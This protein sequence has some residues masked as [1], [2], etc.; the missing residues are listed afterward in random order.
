MSFADTI[1]IT[2]NGVAKVLTRVNS[3]QD[4]TSQYRLRGTADQYDL[5]I[6]HTSFN[7]KARGGIAMNRHN[8]ELIHTVF[9]VAPATINTVRKSYVVLEEAQSDDAT[10]AVQKFDEA[11]VA[12]L[13]AANITKLLNYES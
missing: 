6:R 4:F 10:V 5:K 8:V 1:T 11:F 13:T 2:V 3:G 7:D 12:F 9:A